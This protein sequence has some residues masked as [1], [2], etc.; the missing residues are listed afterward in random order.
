MEELAK[1]NVEPFFRYA[2]E[3]YRIFLQKQAGIAPPWTTDE[4][5]SQFR[6]CNIFREDDKTTA[7]FRDN[8]RH[9]HRHEMNVVLATII[10]RWFNKIET[11]VIL[12][13]NG[14]L[15]NWNSTRAKQL[16]RSQDVIF[17]GAYIINSPP[18]MSKLDGIC[19]NIDRLMDKREID[20][21]PLVFKMM[22][23]PSTQS[24]YKLHQALT[25]FE[26]LGPFMAYEVVTDLRYTD[27]LHCAEDRMTWANP[28]PGA[29]RGICRLN[30]LALDAWSRYSKAHAEILQTAMRKILMESQNNSNWPSTWPKWEMREV[31]HTLCEFDKWERVHKG[32]GRMKQTYTAK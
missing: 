30:N 12:V 9:E 25:K 24:M 14:L 16:L 19:Q 18:G 8:Y 1:M 3:R 26:R 27:V 20:L 31:E 29:L 13:K 32:E 2:R 15:D 4:A 6:F 7:W 17:T 10:F 23:N 22:D 5:L 28:G 11:G 21:Q